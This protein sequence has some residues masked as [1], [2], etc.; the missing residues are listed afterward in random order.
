MD[1]RFNASP[2]FTIYSNMGGF[3]MVVVRDDVVLSSCRCLALLV[4]SYGMMICGWSIS[5]Y[6]DLLSVL[7][8]SGPMKMMLLLRSSFLM[9]KL[10]AWSGF[11]TNVS[12]Q[13]VL[14]N[15]GVGYTLTM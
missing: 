13:V 6:S 12:Q 8:C 2:A 15:G 11:R 14:F 1:P 7:T 4:I 9:Y 10:L 5:S 3:R